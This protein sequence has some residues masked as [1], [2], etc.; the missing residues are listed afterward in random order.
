MWKFKY[1]FE[2]AY[3]LVK[4]KRPCVDINIGFLSQLKKWEESLISKHKDQLYSVSLDKSFKVYFNGVIKFNDF[5][6]SNIV[7]FMVN[8]I[9]YKIIFEDDNYNQL[10]IYQANDIMNHI[11]Y[12]ENLNS[13][14][15][16]IKRNMLNQLVNNDMNRSFDFNAKELFNCFF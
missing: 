13:Q 15:C 16:I 11:F 8:N 9:L 7:V 14:V 2:Y 4:S 12:D 3:N 6:D 5:K 10:D 1:P